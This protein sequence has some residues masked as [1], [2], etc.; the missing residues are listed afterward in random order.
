[1]VVLLLALIALVGCQPQPPAPP[2]DLQIVRRLI[3]QG[4][5]TA[6]PPFTR[7]GYTVIGE[8]RKLAVAAAEVVYPDVS[9]V[10][11]SLSTSP[12]RPCAVTVPREVA[13]VQTLILETDSLAMLRALAKGIRPRDLPSG[14]D[15]RRLRRMVVRRHAI[16]D[17]PITRIL[18]YWM[19]PGLRAWPVLGVGAWDL[20]SHPL[21][22]PADAVLTFAVGIEEP[23]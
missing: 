5:R 23:A 9:C 15:I 20:T 11:A 1:M 10:P 22:I 7:R 8:T 18:P 2:P 14:H 21:P 6:S 19:A 4:F 16:D 17:V 12:R 3:D 13:P